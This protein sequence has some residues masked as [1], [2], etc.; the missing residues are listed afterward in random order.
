MPSL[1]RR[2]YRNGCDDVLTTG[3]E[4]LLI[5]FKDADRY[6]IGQWMWECSIRKCIRMCC[7]S[8]Q[9]VAQQLTGAARLPSGCKV[10]ARVL[11]KIL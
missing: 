4:E 11:D 2:H 7:V 8:K 6:D 5:V 10:F 9:S 1:T 3:D